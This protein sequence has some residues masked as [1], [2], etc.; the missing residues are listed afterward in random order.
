[1][2]VPLPQV[3]EELSALQVEPEVQLLL[4]SSLLL[5]LTVL[6]MVSLASLFS[7]LELAER[8]TVVPCTL[9]VVMLPPMERPEILRLVSDL[10][11]LVLVELSP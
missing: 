9:E 1:V 11:L 10:L 3:P 6:P 8:A 5:P 2:E 4:A 7:V